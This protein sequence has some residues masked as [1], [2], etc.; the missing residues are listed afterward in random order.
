MVLLAWIQTRI[1]GNGG[2]D[3]PHDQTC[4]QIMFFE[5]AFSN[6]KYF[7]KLATYHPPHFLWPIAI[8]TKELI[9]C[10]V[11]K[12]DYL[13]SEQAPGPY[14]RGYINR[15]IHSDF[16]SGFVWELKRLHQWNYPYYELLSSH[17]LHLSSGSVWG[18]KEYNIIKNDRLL[19]KKKLKRKKSHNKFVWKNYLISNS[20][21]LL[22]K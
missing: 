19:F 17:L 22:K 18:P 4:V 7:S 14:E 15:T 3:F 1:W 5:L 13:Q 21:V 9:C 8:Y 20:S 16:S 11:Y 12:P 6:G 2:F 10:P